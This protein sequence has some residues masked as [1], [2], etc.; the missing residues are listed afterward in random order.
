MHHIY[1]ACIDERGMI[2]HRAQSRTMVVSSIVLFLLFLLV[3]TSVYSATSGTLSQDSWD[4][5]S[6]ATNA[7]H[8]GNQNGWAT[9]S[10]KDATLDVINAGADLDLATEIR[11]QAHTT[12]ADFALNPDNGQSHVSKADFLAAGAVSTNS[13]VLGGGVILAPVTPVTPTWAALQSNVHTDLGSYAS[14]TLVDLDGDGLLDLMV[15]E[16]SNDYINAYRNTGSAASPV[17]TLQTSWRLYD[18]AIPSGFVRPEAGDLDGDGDY[19]LLVGVNDG[20]Q[21]GYENIG[22]ASSPAWQ[23][24]SA[25]DGPNMSVLYS[26]SLA[27]PALADLDNDGDL[28]LI[29]GVGN[30]ILFAFLNSS[31]ASPDWSTAAPVTWETGDDVGTY[32]APAL[33]DLNGDGLYDL[34]V[35]TNLGTFWAYPNVG[36]AIS[37]DWGARD[38]TWEGTIDVGSIGVFS[39]G[40]VNGDGI[41][42]LVG[43]HSGGTSHLSLSTAVS[44]PLSGTY[45][46]PVMD[47]GV[48]Y[49]FNTFQFN[50]DTTPVG[51]SIV[52]DVRA[53]NTA[54]FDG[55]WVTI[56]SVTSGVDISSLSDRRYFQYLV[57]LATTDTAVTPM[58]LDAAVGYLKYAGGT[59]IGIDGRGANASIG[60][61]FSLAPASVSQYDVFYSLTGSPTYRDGYLYSA[62]DPGN[63][64]A[65]F[66]I[67][68]VSDSAAPVLAASTGHGNRIYDVAIDGNYAYVGVVSGLAIVDITNPAVPAIVSSLSITGWTFSMVKVGNYLYMARWQ[69]GG[70]AIVDVTD[71]A[72]PVLLSSYDTPGNA[73]YISYVNGYVY[74]SDGSTTGG[75]LIFDV[76]DPTDPQLLTTLLTGGGAPGYVAVK[77]NIAYMNVSTGMRIYDVTDPTAPV[78]LA[79]SSLA[80]SSYAPITISGNVLYTASGNEAKMIDISNPAS[81][82]LIL[83]QPG[84]ASLYRTAVDKNYLYAT[85]GS[86]GV[87]I[88]NL[89]PYAASGEYYSAMIDFGQ[90]LGFTTLNFT[91]DLPVGTTLAVDVRA[92]DSLSI[93]GSWTAWQMDVQ[94]AGDISVLASHRYAQYRV[95]MTSTDVNATPSLQ[96]ISFHYTTYVDSAQLISSPYNT[97][98]ATNLLGGL[99]WNET[100]AAGTDVQLQIRTAANSGGAPGTWSDWAG[101]DGTSSTYW[102]SANTH[103]GGCS[104]S[105]AI[106][107]TTFSPVL[108]DALDDQWIQYRVTLVSSLDTT[109]VVASV[110]LT[111]DAVNV[112]G[113]VVTVSAVSGPTAE[114]NGTATFNVSLGSAPTADVMIQLQNTDLTEGV[115]STSSLLFTT[116]D[117]NIA[118]TVTIT[119][120]NDDIDDGDIPYQ[121]IM[122]AAVSGDANYDDSAFPAIAMSNIDDDTT[123]VTVTPSSGV[124]NEMGASFTFSVRLDS[125]PT[126]DV[127]F[128]LVSSDLTEGTIDIPSLIFTTT[129]WATPQLLTV[130]GVD[131]FIIDPATAYSIEITTTSSADPLYAAH[132]PVDVT[133]TNIE[134]DVAGVTVVALYGTSTTENGGFTPLSLRLTT[135]PTD[136]VTFT[137]ETD[138]F[139]EGYVS[140]NLFG[141]T[142]VTINPANWNRGASITV[143][144]KNDSVVDGDVPYNIVTSAISSDD[145]YYNGLNPADIAMTNIDNESYTVTVSPT[146]GLTTT[147]DGGSATFNIVL[148]APPADDVMINFV[149]SDLTEGLV[150]PDSIL[151]P[152][153]V[154]PSAYGVTVTVTGV[155][156]TLFDDEQGYTIQTTLVSTD[157]NYGAIDPDDVAVTNVDSNRAMFK[158][159]PDVSKSYHGLDV[160]SADINCDGNVDLIVGGYYDQPVYPYDL[161]GEVSIYYGN[162]NGFSAERDVLARSNIDWTSFGKVVVNMGDLNSDGCDDIAVGSQTHRSN[163][164][165]R[166]H[167]F[168][169]S[170]TGLADADSDG[171]TRETDATWTFQ[172]NLGSQFGSAIVAA[173]FDLDGDVDIVIGAGLENNA[174]NTLFDV[175]RVYLFKNNGAG[176]DDPVADGIINVS[177]LSWSWSFSDDLNRTYFGNT[178]GAMV[179]AN[180]NGDAYPDLVMGATGFDNGQADEG[181]VYVFYGSASGFNDAGADGYADLTDVDWMAESDKA[182]AAFGSAVANAGDIDGD[183]ID[184]LLLA[185]GNYTNTDIYQGALYLFKGSS[186]GL[187]TAA[188]VDGIVRADTESD[189]QVF[190]AFARNYLGQSSVDSAGDFNNDGLLDVIAGGPGFSSNFGTAVVYLNDGLGS[191]Q[192]T[193][194]VIENATATTGNYGT[195]VGNLGD[196]NGDGY[197]EVFSAAPNYEDPGYTNEGA[198]F[199]SLSKVQTPG[200]TVSPS[201]GLTTTESGGSATFTVVLDAPFSAPTDT[202][203]IDVSSLNTAEG[204]VLPAELSFKISDWHIPQTVTITGANDVLSDGPVLYTVDL[205]TVVTTD[206]SYDGIDPVNVS[207]TNEDNDVAVEVVVSSVSATEGQTG[208]VRFMRSGEITAPLTVDYSVAGTASSGDFSGLS[209]SVV[210]P[211][212]AVEVDVDVFATNDGL[213]ETDE[214]VVLSL[215]TGAGYTQGI[216]ASTTLT[217]YD[218]DAAGIAVSPASKLVTTESGGRMSFSMALTSQPD[219]NVTI[220]LSSS[221]VAEGVVTP[222]QFIFTPENWSMQQVGTVIGVDDGNTVDGDVDYSIV[223]A[224]AVAVGDADY[225]GMNADDVQVVN[226]DND[227]SAIP[228]VTLSATNPTVNEAGA[229]GLFT[230]SRSGLTTDSLRVFYSAAG[231]AWPGGDYQVLAGAV[232]IA[233]GSSSAVVGI[234]PINDVQVEGDE[235]IVITLARSSGY[236]IDHPS[237]E[238]IIMVDDEQNAQPPFANFWIDQSV[239]EGGAVTVGVELSA[240]ALS[241]PVTI[242]YTVSG[243]ASYPLDHDAIDNDIV[244]A[245]GTNGSVTV[246]IQDDAEVDAGET[247]VFTMGTLANARE[248]LGNT[249]TITTI[250]LN[251][252]AEVALTPVQSTLETRLVVTGDGNV[253]V[254]AL[255]SDPNPADTHSYSWLATNAALRTREVNDADDTTFVFDPTTLADGFYKVRL[256]TTDNGAPNISVDSEL[257]LEVVSV[258]PVL[259][260]TDSDNDGV[261]DSDESFADSDG[262]GVADYLDASTLLSNEL[263]LFSTQ[264]GTYIMQTEAG[265]AL[266]LGDV[267]FAAQGDGAY[268]TSGDISAYGGGE[269]NPGTVTAADTVPNAGGGYVD[270]E[271]TGLPNAGQSV[272]ITIPQ[273]EALPINA[274]YR[275]YH[276]VTGWKNYVEDANN[277]IAS[278]L[279]SP[280]RC[281][282]PGSTDYTAGLT[283]GHYCIQLTIQDGGG[284]DMDGQANRVIKDPAQIGKVVAVS[285]PE[286][287]PVSS[288]GGSLHP[289]SQL[290]L[291]SLFWLIAA[292]RQARLKA[293]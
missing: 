50:A 74:L 282:L 214:T 230:V 78:L 263:Q 254:S 268:V 138:D 281:P 133:A 39:L 71:P 59:D 125:E 115:L 182:S 106:S 233:A 270:F 174:A 271:I 215:L 81:P 229:A 45:E 163:T 158:F 251:E 89:G 289:L 44:Y 63:S 126:A 265:L 235:T 178:Q 144:G 97:T 4:G 132:D 244:I 191:L 203:T 15:G 189:W 192:T 26:Q 102:N 237:R 47:I 168:Y 231:T 105:G 221:N 210:I 66:R 183:G 240:P 199:V 212:G 288:G 249:H 256:T 49:G 37:P 95:R 104:G 7:T 16:Y 10:S 179:T 290:L 68:D 27:K 156:D 110:A 239:G 194:I 234:T 261:V 76:S 292:H 291:L 101:P 60:L 226:R 219:V 124:S 180:V 227:N 56:S 121:I 67:I 277:S 23:H 145:S 177:E 72:A 35:G 232:D 176:W 99:A 188:D 167:I 109:P 257:L 262:D 21:M 127:T 273:M 58:F 33:G 250:E 195:T 159:D 130:T 253:V 29:T 111:Y 3:S 153:G 73:T 279:G 54:T 131:D 79:I 108:R 248:G 173:D 198:V 90:H 114:P 84:T 11:T 171:I 157:P 2:L 148:G 228:R 134:D 120:V 43:G 135:M 193:P 100:L 151:F 64:N 13:K 160:T 238:T 24:N 269:G 154:A 6:A 22:T 140:G 87:E 123:G 206:T 139:S 218:N 274:V 38:A 86:L 202:L 113:G 77:G 187:V 266:H 96:D 14:P 205:A 118:Q 152:A 204:T 18:A 128:G 40:D 242:P 17:W 283:A 117:W 181:R 46:S 267:A 52:V 169:G 91:E 119:G 48:H 224:A 264:T 31:S 51:T 162:G 258:A 92:G 172:G 211:A 98:D 53:G 141:P 88:F 136:P 209:T 217:I 236:I 220:G 129:D 5:G 25:F 201:T 166:V 175:G 185:A 12:D 216:P 94:N 69:T 30:G 186:T 278:A 213:V 260:A 200:V 62:D 155:D 107:C 280:G 32:A 61:S 208:R 142:T 276:P 143:V 207:V 146:T 20:R 243:S 150:S 93:D 103:A 28:D 1:D 9:Y 287:A 225:N 41:L 65:R 252:A 190:G 149:S 19:D 75:M 246:N 34:I 247:I 284:N 85:R 82:T 122:A 83:S 223:T 70:L 36:T 116:G 164:S 241:Y 197:S 245:S 161:L 55:S 259:T 137:V 255:V 80:A 57:T 42:D 170:A 196:I 285:E 184:D 293:C 165:G 272:M 222:S 112:A 275:K 286:V 147:E 8:P